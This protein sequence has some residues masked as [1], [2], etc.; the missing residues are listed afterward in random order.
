MSFWAESM[1]FMIIF[2]PVNL[3]ILPL[4]RDGLCRRIPVATLDSMS[5]LFFRNNKILSMK[6]SN[7]CHQQSQQLQL[8]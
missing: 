3:I 4:N 5:G 6:I 2:Q 7:F 8:H 1:T